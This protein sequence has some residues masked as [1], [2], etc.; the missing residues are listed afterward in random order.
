MEGNRTEV[1]AEAEVELTGRVVQMG[2]GLVQGVAQ[3]LFAEFA[4]RTRA[5]LE[6]AAAGADDALPESAPIRALPLMLRALWAAIVRIF[7]RS[8]RSAGT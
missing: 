4:S 3:Q 8:G 5:S 6:G 1:V 2:R 7:R